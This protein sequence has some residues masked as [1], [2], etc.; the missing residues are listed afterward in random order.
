MEVLKSLEE[1]KMIDTMY[2]ENPKLKKSSVWD[3]KIVLMGEIYILPLSL[4]GDLLPL[5][6]QSSPT[7]SSLS[8]GCCC[9]A[10]AVVFGFLQLFILSFNWW[11]SD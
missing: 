3:L 9:A 1:K 4:R 8:G 6:L 5:S 2:S 7:A 10:V 11:R